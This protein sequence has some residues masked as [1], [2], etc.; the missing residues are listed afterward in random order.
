[1]SSSSRENVTIVTSTATEPQTV[2]GTEMKMKIETTIRL[3][4]ITASMDNAINL[5]KRPQGC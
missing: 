1:M 5:K 3:Q 2:G 4:E